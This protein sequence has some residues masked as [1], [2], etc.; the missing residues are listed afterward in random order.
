MTELR[1]TVDIKTI[2]EEQRTATGAVL[3]PDELDHQ[4]D[5]LRPDAVQNFHSDD[6]ETGVMHSAFP[7]DAAE[8]ERNEVIDE[9]EQIGDETYPPG[10]WVATRRYED[11]DLWQLVEDGVLEG[12]SIGG[13]VSRAA[14]HDELPDDVRVPDGVDH[15]RGGTELLA[16]RV[17]EVSD[18]DIPAVPR[19]TYK[20]EMG[21]SILD[22]VDGEAEFVELMTEQRGH[23]EADARQLYQYLTDAR[24][25]RRD[26]FQKPIVLPNGA[27]FD[28]F[29]ACVDT[30]SED[31][32]REQAAQICGAGRER[33]K[34]EVNGTNIDLTP[35]V[36]M[37]AA[38]EAAA[39]AGESGLIPSDCGTGTGDRRRG[40]ILDG[41]LSPDV[42]REIA[43]YLVS[44]E[45]DVT[46]DGPPSE[47]SDEEWADCGNA[48]YAKWGGTGGGE[49]MEWA[50]RRVNEIDR[51][52]DDPL[53]YEE[54]ANVADKNIDDPAFNEGDAVM[55]SS[56]DTPVHGRVAGVHEQFSPAGADVT[57]TGDEGEAV[58]S[59]FEWDD[60]LDEP[61]FRDAPSQPN[62]AKPESSLD[63]ST[64]DM[65]PATEEHFA[66]KQM[67]ND[68][69]QTGEPDDATKWRI[70]KRVFFGS[71]D[72]SAPEALDQK[73]SDGDDEED[74]EEDDDEEMANN[75]PAGDTADSDMSDDTTKSDEPPAWATSLTE[76]VEQIDKRVADLEG[77]GDDE[78]DKMADA[79]EWAEDLV[80]KVDDLDERVDAIS[81]QSGK[82]QQLDAVDKNGSDPDDEA[83]A[84]KRRLV[85]A[86][87]GGDDR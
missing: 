28:T 62:V 6:V 84:Y 15:E 31:M 85:G 1:K 41:E 68:N 33:H 27:E 25:K 4:H 20:G 55:W 12:F 63:E 13:E 75:A 11:D 37:V 2:D 46:A 36:S 70:L 61:V 40:Q 22:E 59:I 67:S 5:F 42:V 74:D 54:V 78:T 14:D 69:T 83:E 30:L 3:V 24:T 7:D 9:S 60:S 16:G 65:P 66:S 29:D 17:E 81:Q 56:Q 35:P 21:K 51:A 8:L 18:V 38:A 79:P 49:P 80:D 23:D 26:I 50:M 43:S 72:G 87:T 44:H 52:R 48:Q 86:A 53:T 32:P 58:Y 82:S 73:A 57:I 19:A 45:E 77:E 34:V 10:T 47:W 39:D 64:L 71:D 76:T